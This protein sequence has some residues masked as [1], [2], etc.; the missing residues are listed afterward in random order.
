MTIIN[1]FIFSAVNV[2]F[3]ILRNN[4]LYLNAYKNFEK[5]KKQIQ[6]FVFNQLT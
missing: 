3:K 6:Q 5:K 4:R 1:D 2:M